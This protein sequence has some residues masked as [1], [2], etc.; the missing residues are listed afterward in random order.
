MW[1]VVLATTNE[2][3]KREIQRILAPTGVVVAFP[4]LPLPHV[5]EDGETFADNARLKAASAAATLDRFALAEDSGLVVPALGGEPGVR[6]ARYAGERATDAENNAR[7]LRELAAHGLEDPPASY[8]CHAVVCDPAGRVVAEAEGTAEGTIRTP[9][10]GEDGFGYDPLFHW[11]GP[12]A[13]RGGLRFAQLPAHEK[14]R[15]SHRGRALRLL[16][17]RLRAAAAGR[18]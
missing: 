3:K 10:L 6:S 4:A 11:R 17:E 5:E 13:P 1:T 7:L 9:A 18:T 2:G 12:G 15:V 14:D 8:V 16:A